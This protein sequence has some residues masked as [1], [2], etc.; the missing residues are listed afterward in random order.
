M[1][2]DI[3][4]Q[5][6]NKESKEIEEILHFEQYEIHEFF[7][8]EYIFL[9]D[10]KEYNITNSDREFCLCLITLREYL[11]E[12]RYYKA[13]EN[14]LREFEKYDTLIDRIKYVLDSQVVSG[15]LNKHHKFTYLCHK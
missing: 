11:D 10:N 8:D 12:E 2:Y 3:Y 13:R 5:A 1:G 4:I 14:N 6:E 15:D 7:K 9:E